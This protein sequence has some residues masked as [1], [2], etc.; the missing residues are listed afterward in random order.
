MKR[1]EHK[2]V[3]YSYEFEDVE[4]RTIR[5]C[6][7]YCRHRIDNHPGSGITKGV[8][9]SRICDILNMLTLFRED[10]E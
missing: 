9:R 8:E 10:L 7:A 6:L 1:H 2:H 5:E 3:T 4:I